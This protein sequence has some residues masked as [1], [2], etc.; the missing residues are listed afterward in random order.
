VKPHPEG[1]PIKLVRDRTPAIINSSGNPGDLFYAPLHPADVMP[2]LKKKLAEE[3]AE[4]LVDGG[5]GEL[6]DVVVVL[7]ALARV[8]GRTLATLLGVGTG[9]RGGFRDAVMMYGRHPEYD[10]EAA[11]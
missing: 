10:R 5:P 7:D 4:Y 2:W 1:Y 11:P 6:A 8:H 9:D 3:V